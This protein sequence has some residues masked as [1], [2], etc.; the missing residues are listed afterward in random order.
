[1][2]H[3]NEQLEGYHN[4]LKSRIPVLQDHYMLIREPMTH[5]VIEVERNADLNSEIKH[6]QP[7]I[8][9]HGLTVSRLFY[10]C[11]MRELASHG[12]FVLSFTHNDGSAD[13]S[14]VTGCY[15]VSE[16]YDYELRHK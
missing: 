8:F 4:V 6:L 9:S 10:S 14:E 1:M 11:W 13:Y 2:P 15:Q 3:G 7:V 16:T 12:F 5:T